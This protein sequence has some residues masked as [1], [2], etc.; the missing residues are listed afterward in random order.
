MQ[1]IIDS[2]KETEAKISAAS[3]KGKEILRQILELQEQIAECNLLQE[4]YATLRGQYVSTSNAF[5]LLSMVKL[6]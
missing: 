3:S 4:R 2:I 1:E 5:L 6:K